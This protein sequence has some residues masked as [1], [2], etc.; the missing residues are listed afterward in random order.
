MPSVTKRQ[1]AKSQLNAAVRL[2][3]ACEEPLVVH[4]LAVNAANLYSDLIEKTTSVE[5][6]RQNMRM[7]HGMSEAEIRSVLHR[8]WNFF[9]HADRDPN[10][11]LEF[12]PDETDYVIFYSTLECGEL[13]PTSTEMQVFQL[14][15][16]ATERFNLGSDNEIQRAAESLFPGLAGLD[17]STQLEQGRK[18]LEQQLATEAL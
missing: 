2:R 14:W 4:T 3:F 7:D 8:A 9:K 15:F 16:L 18:F 1:A 6:W 11:S 5:S 17:R 10:D 12:E 13:E